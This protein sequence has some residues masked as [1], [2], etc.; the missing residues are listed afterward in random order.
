MNSRIHVAVGVIFNRI[1]DTVLLSKRG[2]HQH[3]AGYWEFPGGK[4]NENENVEQALRREL[5]EELGIVVNHTTPFMQLKHDYADKKVF[6]DIHK[7]VDWSGDA[8]SMEQQ[9]IKWVPVRELHQYRFPAANLDIVKLLTLPEVYLISRSNYHCIGDLTHV[10]QDCINAGLSIFQLRLS[11]DNDI[12]IREAI[13]AVNNLGARKNITLIL[14]G[15]AECINGYDIDGVHLKSNLLNTYSERPV[16]RN[17]LLGA[18][19]HNEEELEQAIRLDVD[20]VFISPIKSTT[21]HL[22]TAPIGWSEF[23]R[24]CRYMD[25]PVY[26]LGGMQPA[27]LQ[28]AINYGAR[29]VAL[30]EAV[31]GADNPG[32]TI[33]SMLSV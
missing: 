6:L 5:S 4:L 16:P 29:G 21:S 32:K 25:K 30:I 14:N 11:D 22:G 2:S 27:D 15:K 23:E 19:C 1:Q 3:L 17:Y 10:L 28:P 31:W 26:A 33:S 24:L 18:S 12:G 20:Y 13:E 7:V 8:R 9:E